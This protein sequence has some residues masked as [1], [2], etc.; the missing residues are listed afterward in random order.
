MRIAEFVELEQFGRERFAARVSLTLVLV[1]AY[2][3]FSGHAGV[4]LGGAQLCCAHHVP[5]FTFVTPAY[6]QR[7]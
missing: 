2:F 7:R 6:W 4:P 3:Q 1:D 5:Y